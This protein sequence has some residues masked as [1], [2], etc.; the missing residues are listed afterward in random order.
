M[1]NKLPIIKKKDPLWLGF[2]MLALLSF[3]GGV[4]FTAGAHYFNWL[5]A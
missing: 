3:L 1:E 2:V 4:G 5:I